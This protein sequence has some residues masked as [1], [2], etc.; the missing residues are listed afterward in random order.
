MT[1]LI[2]EPLPKRNS[3][4]HNFE[5]NLR[6]LKLGSCCDHVSGE[7]FIYTSCNTSLW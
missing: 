1:V 5:I 7:N 4:C 2:E 3:L 6:W